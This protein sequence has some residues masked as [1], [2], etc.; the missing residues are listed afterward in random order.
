MI[1]NNVPQVQ[2]IY[3]RK[4]FCEASYAYFEKRKFTTRVTMQY[5]CESALKFR[6]LVKRQA[7]IIEVKT[8]VVVDSWAAHTQS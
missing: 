1:I 8:C 3:I 2:D 5:K 7:D 6:S 4:N